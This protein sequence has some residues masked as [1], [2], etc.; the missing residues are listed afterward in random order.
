MELPIENRTAAGRAL[1]EALKAYADR[2]DV[3]VL[4]L[5][6]G[7]VAVAYEVIQSIHA[8]LDLLL[9]RKLGTPGHEELAMGAITTGGTRVLNEN[10]IYGLSISEETINQ[11]AEREQQELERRQ[12]VYRG[13]RPLPE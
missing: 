10:V 5:P 12:H 7:G 13:D 11:V 6:R 9:V 1:G 2:E 3:I 8:P 4:A